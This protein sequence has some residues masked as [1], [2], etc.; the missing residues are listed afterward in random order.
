MYPSCA[1]LLVRWCPDYERSTAMAIYT[2]GRQMA[3]I[4]GLP[5]AAWF[6]DKHIL[7]GWSGIFYLIGIFGV[8]ICTAW[9]FLVTNSPMDH[10]LISEKE[11]DSLMKAQ[12]E[13]SGKKV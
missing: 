13:I 3:I 7:G 6:C 11:K 8:I 2:C 10:R 1:A 12:E 9:V 4:I 5:L